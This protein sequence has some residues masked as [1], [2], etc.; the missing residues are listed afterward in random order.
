[1]IGTR[2]LLKKLVVALRVGG[3]I[4]GGRN[5]DA[6]ASL[7]RLCDRDERGRLRPA[8]VSALDVSG[9]EPDVGEPVTGLACLVGLGVHN[10]LEERPAIT[11]MGS[12]MFTMPS[13]KL[14]IRA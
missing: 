11:L 3:E 5:G 1:M 10:L 12:A 9:V 6:D 7:Y 14:G 4:E 13:S 2:S 8:L